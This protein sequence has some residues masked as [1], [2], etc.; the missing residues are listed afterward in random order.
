MNVPKLRFKEF[1]DE[2]QEH[3][4]K[5]FTVPVK[6]K[7]TN[8]E[9]DLP[10]TISSLDGL[11]DQRTYFNKVVASKDM[12]NYY[13]LKKGE[14]AYNKSYSVGFPF[15]SI[16]RLDK[17]NQGALSSLYICF[18]VNN[19]NSD[20][21]VKYFESP[22]WHKQ[23]S[24]CVAEGARN[25]GL[26]NV[27]INDFFSTKHFFPQLKEQQKIAN[28]LSTVDKKISNLEDIVTN[29]ENQKKGLLQQ[30]FNQG[31]RFKD[32]NGNN[33]PD[34]KHKQLGDIATLK[35][36]I[37]KGNEAFGHGK[38][39][40][41]L[42]DIFNKSYIFNDNYSLVDV[43]EKELSENNLLKGDVLFVRSSVKREGVG[44]PCVIMENL[45]D[46]VYSGFIIRCRFN[47]NENIYLHYKKYCF[48]ESSFRKALLKKSSSSAN[49]NINQDNLSK[50]YVKLPCLEEQTKIADF[51]SAFDRKIDNQKA[52][53]EHWKQIKKG[54]LQ[55]M[56]V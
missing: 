53:L 46:T 34:W 56:F 51:L 33:Y 4:L 13:L 15:G 20:F 9:S 41:N 29:L 5:D 16:K 10:L 30:I 45:I 48:L 3:K 32:E 25:H 19:M 12:S 54:L 22:K 50:L 42:Q 39:F 21:T 11:V 35:N 23:I 36:G 18:Q 47:T 17:Y 26:L 14:F 28:F 7:N 1:T 31:I 44:L 2:W 49:T 43:T 55:Q 8:N 40:I 38:K 24:L 37:S 6:R 27:N 52:Q